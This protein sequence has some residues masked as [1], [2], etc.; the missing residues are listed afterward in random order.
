MNIIETM[1]LSNGLKTSPDKE[2]LKK[3]IESLIEYLE[4][5]HRLM[6]PLGL[7]IER[8]DYLVTKA[9]LKLF[10]I[11]CFFLA[12]NFFAGVVAPLF[13]EKLRKNKKFCTVPLISFVIGLTIL[14]WA[15]V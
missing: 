1:A 8:S 7:T 15:A 10:G 3:Y 13:I 14:F 12:V 6:I 5:H 2:R 9:N 4:N 11:L